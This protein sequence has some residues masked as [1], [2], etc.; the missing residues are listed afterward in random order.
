MTDKIEIPATP[1]SEYMKDS[2]IKRA[3]QHADI[4]RGIS[5]R[6]AHHIESFLKSCMLDFYSDMIEWER[7]KERVY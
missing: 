2:L 3:K 6:D 1:F 7:K 4:I 5:M